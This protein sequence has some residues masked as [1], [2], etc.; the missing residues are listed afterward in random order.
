[1]EGLK[2]WFVFFEVRLSDLDF[3]LTY[4]SPWF[5]YVVLAMVFYGFDLYL[6]Q[7]A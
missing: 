4:L 6:G 3:S 7:H 2:F 1:V 5:R